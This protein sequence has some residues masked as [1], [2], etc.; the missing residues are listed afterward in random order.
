MACM[1]A[2]SACENLPEQFQPRKAANQNGP[3]LAGGTTLRFEERDI[4]VPDVFGVTETAI[5]DGKP[6]FGGVW[7]AYPTNIKPERVIITNL[8]NNDTVVGALFKSEADNPGPKLRLSSDAARELGIVAGEPTELKVVAIRRQPVQLDAPEPAPAPEPTGTPEPVLAAP[9]VAPVP[10][11]I[12]TEILTETLAEA[13]ETAPKP[14]PQKAEPTAPAATPAPAG[15]VPA[16]PFIQVATLT[17]EANASTLEKRLSD[18]GIT[19]LIRLS[20]TSTGKE[21][22]RVL[23]GPAITADALRELSEKIS[24][25][26]FSDAFPVTN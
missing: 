5:W 24:G 17:S 9:V 23:A 10:T 15:N 1:T 12:E 21:L 6:S 20:K 22:Y 25:L 3:N 13:I 4:E 26:G 7:V 2:L 14:R 11:P 18:A 19:S 16:K 8:S